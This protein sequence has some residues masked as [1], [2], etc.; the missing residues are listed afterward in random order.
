MQEFQELVPD[1][2]TFRRVWQRVMG[3]REDSPIAVHRPDRGPRPPERPRPPQRPEPVKD[4]GLLRQILEEMDGAMGRVMTIARRQ[5]GAGALA[6]SVRRSL[7]RARSA[8]FL[9]T[10]RRWE[11]RPAG[12]LPMRPVGELLREQ[13]LWELNFSRLCR[14]AAQRDRSEELRELGEELE[15]ESRRRRRMIRNLLGGR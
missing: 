5:P 12:T 11:S 2:E 15:Q 9:L 4:E 7:S 8:W 1:E 14:D 6:D 13:Y 3:D 10:G